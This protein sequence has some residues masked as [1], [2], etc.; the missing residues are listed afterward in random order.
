M[1]KRRFIR[2]RRGEGFTLIELLVVIAIIAILAA[3]LLPALSR[4]REKA[5]QRICLNNQ[6]QLITA[7][8]MY[9][10]DFDGY[11]PPGAQYPPAYSPPWWY[12]VLDPYAGG[13]VS[14]KL[15]Y[16][17]SSTRKKP[18]AVPSI[19]PWYTFIYAT[20]SAKSMERHVIDTTNPSTAIVFAD[21]YKYAGRW[22][23]FST[24]KWPDPN[25]KDS[26]DMYRHNDGIV[27]TF[28]D[29]HGRW[30]S[31]MEAQGN[32]QYWTRESF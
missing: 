3:M 22:A 14:T 30:M 29:G 18:P 15:L 11:A 4:A 20:T 2:H 24:Y 9:V 17:P 32:P 8:K 19:G 16:C 6:K 12:T 23:R 25:H 1:R 5:R 27:A 7:L 10:M 26:V 21:C 28:W 13:K 31:R